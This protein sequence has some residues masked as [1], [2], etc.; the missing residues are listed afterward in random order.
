MTQYDLHK[1]TQLSIEYETKIGTLNK[2]V[3]EKKEE[4]IQAQKFLEK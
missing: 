2:Q 4:A 1:A 3:E